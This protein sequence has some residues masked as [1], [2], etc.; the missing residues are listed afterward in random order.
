MGVTFLGKQ[1][2]MYKVVSNIHKKVKKFNTFWRMR[3]CKFET[4]TDT[5]EPS[6]KLCQYIYI[7]IF[8]GNFLLNSAVNLYKIWNLQACI[9]FIYKHYEIELN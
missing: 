7:Y 2:S 8:T 6:H 3:I 1:F 9:V 4:L 5:I